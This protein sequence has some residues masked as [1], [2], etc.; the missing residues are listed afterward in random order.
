MDL[1]GDVLEDAIM[2]VAVATRVVE[3]THRYA[4]LV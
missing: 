3:A 4:L 1:L 2:F